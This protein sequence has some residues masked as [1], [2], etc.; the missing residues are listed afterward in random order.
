MQ[1]KDLKNYGKS[2]TEML[3][4]VPPDLEKK[5]N[6][7]GKRKVTKELG[8]LKSLRF[9]L[10]VRKERSRMAK[11]DLSAVREK[12][13]TDEE[14]IHS[15]IEWAAMFSA[16][17]KLL[18]SERAVDLLNEVMEATAPPAFAEM[19]P[20]AADMQ[21]IEGDPFTA[22]KEYQRAGPEAAKR[23]GCHEMEI[24]EDTDDALQLNIT[25]CA[26][27]EIA[28]QLG[29]QQA[30]RPSCYSDDVI[31]PGY[32]EPL[33]IVFKRTNTLARGGTHCDFR[34]ERIKD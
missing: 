6:R 18:G 7:I 30:C 17:S 32:L 25:Y 15:Q 12:G 10:L 31:L 16:L 24:V 8:L 9:V 26:W 34:F 33:G 29:V 3:R 4:T 21:G 1:V 20:T 14:F 28:K 23:A 5:L 13:L 11:Q 19:L 2:M 27:N 22:F